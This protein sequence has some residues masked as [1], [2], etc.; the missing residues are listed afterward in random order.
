METL[1]RVCRWLRKQAGI[2]I[3]VVI[4]VISGCLIGVEHL[5]KFQYSLSGNFAWA[6]GELPELP[7]FTSGIT[8]IAAAGTAILA[9]AVGIVIFRRLRSVVR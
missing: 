8:L 7:T 3:V 5:G 1:K 6:T 2:V 4:T 9:L